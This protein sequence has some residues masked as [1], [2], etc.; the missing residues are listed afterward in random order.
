MYCSCLVV[1][2]E[3]SVPNKRPSHLNLLS[4]MAVTRWLKGLGLL[5]KKSSTFSRGVVLKLTLAHGCGF[6]K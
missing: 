6:K 4:S 1:L 5:T 3:A 2:P